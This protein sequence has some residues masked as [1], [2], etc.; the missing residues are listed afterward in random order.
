MNRLN[1]VPVV[2]SDGLRASFNT[3]HMLININEPHTMQVTIAD[4]SAD[5]LLIIMPTNIPKG[6]MHEYNTISQRIYELVYASVFIRR[7][8]YV[9]SLQE[10]MPRPICACILL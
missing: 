9:I 8:H 7:M 10:P 3:S 5:M 6:D 2:I 4:S 1:S